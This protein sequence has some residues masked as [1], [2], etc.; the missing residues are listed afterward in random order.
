MGF[1]SAGLASAQDTIEQA[2][3]YWLANDDAAAFPALSALA[4]AGDERAMLFLGA[5]ELRSLDSAY[6]AQLDRETRNQMLRAP[7]GIS[8]KSWLLQVTSDKSRASALLAARNG[9][10]APLLALNEQYAASVAILAAFNSA[11]WSLVDLDRVTPVPD[12][13]RH[14]VWAG[15]DMG[16]SPEVSGLTLE[17]DKEAE[18][19]AALIHATDPE[20]QDS[21]QMALY[22]AIQQQ[23]SSLRAPP[24]FDVLA[25][26]ILLYGGFEVR[27]R[28]DFI[29]ATEAQ[30]TAAGTRARDPCLRTRS[31]PVARHLHEGRPSRSNCLHRNDLV[32]F[33]R[34]TDDGCIPYAARQSRGSIG[35]SR[36]SALSRRPPPCGKGITPRCGCL[37][38]SGNFRQLISSSLV[39]S[40]PTSMH[41][42]QT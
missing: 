5:I 42:R 23:Y 21:L 20:W 30:R 8:G 18:L 14:L 19:R 1:G 4:I 12:T 9:D 33:R 40:P 29:E 3:G 6:L 15:A 39:L 38:R 13:L 36:K 17:G 2:I 28:D 37:W 10:P 26:Q 25:G 31:S 7:G 27:T 16:L 24:P 22:Q 34:R 32:H 11:P 41:R 35:L